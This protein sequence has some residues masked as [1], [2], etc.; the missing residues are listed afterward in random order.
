MR[1]GPRGGLGAQPPRKFFVTTPLSLSENEGNNL[2]IT[3]YSKK[4]PKHS[5]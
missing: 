1:T 3:N 5:V 2:F 4:L